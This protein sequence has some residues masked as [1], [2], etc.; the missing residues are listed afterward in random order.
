MCVFRGHNSG[1]AHNLGFWDSPFQWRT[2]H[3]TYLSA[4]PGFRGQPGPGCP[5]R[6]AAW[7]RRYAGCS[8]GVRPAFRKRWLLSERRPL[9]LVLLN[10]LLEANRV[11]FSH[12]KGD[13]GP[14]ACVPVHWD[15]CWLLRAHG[16]PTVPVLIR[17]F[18]N[19][20]NDWW[21]FF[22]F[23]KENWFLNFNEIENKWC[24]AIDPFAKNS[25]ILRIGSCFFVC[26]ILI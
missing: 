2:Q 26:L 17:I 24:I 9:T 14:G 15:S 22:C 8:R 16:Y 10:L 23:L 21:V 20:W 5:W 19:F 11:F 4:A 6:L 12:N 1:S 7:G 18:H 3:H 13:R 25:H